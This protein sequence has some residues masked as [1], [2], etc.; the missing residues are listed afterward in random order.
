MMKMVDLVAIESLAIANKLVQKNFI[1]RN[2]LTLATFLSVCFAGLSCRNSEALQKV[3]GS[4]PLLTAVI[5]F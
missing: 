4:F 5:A 1:V 2:K 3:Q